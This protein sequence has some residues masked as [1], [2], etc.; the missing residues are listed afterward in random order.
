MGHKVLYVEQTQ[1]AEPQALLVLE[2]TTFAILRA[3]EVT[4]LGF[5]TPNTTDLI[6]TVLNRPGNALND[7]L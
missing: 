4:N 6:A 5:E 2:L 1:K 3:K 7:Y